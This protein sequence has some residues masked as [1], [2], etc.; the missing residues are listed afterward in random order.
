VSDWIHLHETVDVVAGQMHDYL[1]GLNEMFAPLGEERGISMSGVFEVV[2]GG[3]RPQ[4]VLLW[5][6]DG[7]LAYAR[8]RTTA[9]SHPGVGR[10]HTSAVGWRTGGFDRMLSPLPL[11]PRPPVRPQSKSAGCVVLQHTYLVRPGRGAAFIAAVGDSVITAA[12]EREV[13][14]EAF[15][16]SC[17][18][19]SEFLA[20]WSVPGVDALARVREST[21]DAGSVPGVDVVAGE[22][23]G[24]EER[25]LV[26][27]DF[28]PLGGAGG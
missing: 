13:T 3:R 6:I 20:M 4:A 10:W 23:A 28:S 27:A 25:V 21:T 26:P 1:A 11:S 17:F 16:R 14:L 12:A 2:E 5:N 7:W 18:R 15:W 8:Q 22:L 24:I 9:G 19:P